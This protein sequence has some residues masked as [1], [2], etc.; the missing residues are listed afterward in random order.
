[1]QLWTSIKIGQLDVGCQ[2]QVIMSHARKMKVPKSRLENEVSKPC[3]QC[4]D[5]V[6]TL[7]ANSSPRMQ[8][9]V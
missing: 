2:E 9:H 8:V 3:D 7:S 6:A 5:I 4:E 1:M